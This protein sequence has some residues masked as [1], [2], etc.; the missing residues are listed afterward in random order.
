[1]IREGD[2]AVLALTHDEHAA[3]LRAH[4]DLVEIGL[5][6]A[7]GDAAGRLPETAGRIAER[8]LGHGT[9]RAQHAA[10]RVEHGRLGDVSRDVEQLVE[11]FLNGQDLIGGSR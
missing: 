11:C 4:L 5:A 8:L 3:E 1:M 6:E 2:D 9:V 7:L 10:F